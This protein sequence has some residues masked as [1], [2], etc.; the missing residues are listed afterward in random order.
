MT[1]LNQLING[2]YS[3]NELKDLMDENIITKLTR[4]TKVKK[5]TSV[6]QG[7]I[8]FAILFKDCALGKSG[9][10]YCYS[11]GS[12]KKGGQIVP[13]EMKS[14]SAGPDDVGRVK[15]EDMLPACGYEQVTSLGDENAFNRG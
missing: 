10:I 5:R 12:V 3:G 11:S 4:F 8:L 7:E 9:D 2:A 13:V 6:G 1:T 15:V 14:N